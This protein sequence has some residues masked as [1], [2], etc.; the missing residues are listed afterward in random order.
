MTSLIAHLSSV[1]IMS[2]VLYTLIVALNCSLL[3]LS[4]GSSFALIVSVS[5]NL[6][7]LWGRVSNVGHGPTGAFSTGPPNQTPS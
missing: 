2:Y 4:P 1:R 6:Q 3:A 5:F 7:R